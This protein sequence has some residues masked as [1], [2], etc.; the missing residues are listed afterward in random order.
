MEDPFARARIL[1]RNRRYD[2]AEVEVRERLGLAPES[3]DGFILLSI[4]RSARGDGSGVIWAER[5]L[6]LAPNDARAL[7]ALGWAQLKGN[8]LAEAEASLRRAVE[9]NPRESY[10]LAMLSAVLIA[11]AAWSGAVEAAE[12]GLAIDPECDGCLNNRAVALKHLGRCTEALAELRAGLERYPEIAHFHANIG[13]SLLDEIAPSRA[14][15]HFREALRLDPQNASAKSGLL[16][17]LRAKNGFYRICR[18]YF[19][20]RLRLWSEVQAALTF[21]PT[22][23]VLLP[24]SSTI[25]VR[26]SR[27]STP[28][29]LRV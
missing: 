1:Y 16:E 26:E 23:L 10:I 18:L 2:L 20:I 6:E 14:V 13:W 11:R 22:L 19:L 21:G 15:C 29:P 17:A 27:S 4:C 24:F 12:S 28:F 7:Y 5:A 3:P 8:R 25:I 9:A